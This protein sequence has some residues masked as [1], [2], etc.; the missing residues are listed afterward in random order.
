MKRSAVVA[1]ACILSLFLASCASDRRMRFSGSEPVVRDLAAFEAELR[2]AAA[3]G[4][5]VS[6]EEAGRVSR[7]GFESP[8]WVVSVERPGA[9][10]RA[11]VVA[12]IHGNEPAGPAWAVELVRLLATDPSVFPG[13]HSTSC[14]C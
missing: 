12:G 2:A 11:L 1:I 8:L 4:D 13:C 6:V 10:K 14:P 7:E 9:A 5:G 3:G